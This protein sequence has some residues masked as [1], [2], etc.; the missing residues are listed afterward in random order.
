MYSKF[1]GYIDGEPLHEA[2]FNAP[3]ACTYDPEEETFYLVD[4]GNHC[5]R[6]LRT[7]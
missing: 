3:R 5:I 2:R 4:N 1:D 7:E 6:Y